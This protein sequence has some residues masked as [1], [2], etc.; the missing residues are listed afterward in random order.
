[1]ERREGRTEIEDA[2]SAGEREREGEDEE[3]RRKEGKTQGEQKSEEENGEMRECCGE[4][5]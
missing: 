2:E 5:E 1:M 3:E 4:K